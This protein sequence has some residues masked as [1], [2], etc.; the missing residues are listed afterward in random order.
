[1]YWGRGSFQE[2]PLVTS[3]WGR[4]SQESQDSGF[5]LEIRVS[6][7]PQVGLAQGGLTVLSTVPRG[8]VTLTPC[9]GV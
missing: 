7:S 1:M 2:E 5:N 9:P 6:A 3:E 4:G 8:F